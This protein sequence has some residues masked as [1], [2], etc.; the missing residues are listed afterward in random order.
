VKEGQGE[1][2]QRVLLTTLTGSQRRE[3]T[4]SEN[5]V[6]TTVDKKVWCVHLTNHSLVSTIITIQ[7]IY[8]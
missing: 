8:R 7:E 1:V 5:A 6:E 3:K 4:G 2:L